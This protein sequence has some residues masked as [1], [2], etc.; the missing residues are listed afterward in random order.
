M[1]RTLLLPHLREA[2]EER[3][4]SLRGLERATGISGDTILDLEHGNR[5]A[6]RS[7]ILK[8]ASILEVDPATLVGTYWEMNEKERKAFARLIESGRPQSFFN[9]EKDSD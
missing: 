3:G 5:R 7:T 9:E 2:R 6:Y 4:F 8:L 1:S